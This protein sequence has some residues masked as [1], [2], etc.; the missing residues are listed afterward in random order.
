MTRSVQKRWVRRRS[1]QQRLTNYERYS[2]SRRINRA[3]NS[4]RSALLS[5]IGRSMLGGFR[6][7]HLRRYWKR[8]RSR[9]NYKVGGALL[10]SIGGSFLARAEASDLAQAMLPGITAPVQSL[11]S[12]GRKAVSGSRPHLGPP[13]RFA[14]ARIGQQTLLTGSPGP[15]RGRRVRQPSLPSGRTQS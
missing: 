9:L 10:A 2:L 13:R 14:V 3:S 1:E 5:V 12:L 6:S 11:S 7:P 4:P 8:Q 15:A